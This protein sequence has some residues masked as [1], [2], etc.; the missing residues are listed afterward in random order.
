M[1]GPLPPLHRLLLIIVALLVGVGSGAWIAH[2]TPVPLAASAGAALGALAG[3]LLGYV[4]I[5]D[6]SNR[7]RALRVDR[8]D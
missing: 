7:Q 1:F 6:F 2:F 4:L 8:R 3:V 5:H